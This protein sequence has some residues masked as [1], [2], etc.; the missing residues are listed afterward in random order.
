MVLCG[1]SGVNM[2]HACLIYF[3]LTHFLQTNNVI[4][5]GGLRVCKYFD[6][7][8]FFFIPENNLF[9][10]T[11]HSILEGRSALNTL[12][13]APLPLVP[14]PKRPHAFFVSFLKLILKLPFSC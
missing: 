8:H 10:T 4:R 7:F 12:G 9:Q 14:Y 1:L 13:G 5:N 6:E 11:R 2:S 3:V